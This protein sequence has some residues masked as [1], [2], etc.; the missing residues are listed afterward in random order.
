MPIEVEWPIARPRQTARRAAFLA[1]LLAGETAYRAAQVLDIPYDRAK[2]WRSEFV[3]S[4][5]YTPQ[6]PPV[7]ALMEA[8]L[9]AKLELLLQFAQ[10]T[11]DP[12]YL[13]AQPFADLARG[14][15]GVGDTVVR[16]SERLEQVG[17]LA[18]PDRPGD[19][20]EGPAE[21]GPPAGG[22]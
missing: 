13:L 14:I 2:I 17:R 8:I 22:D 21:A 12:E 9:V 1:H 10:V 15:Q 5:R 16:L 20:L 11:N 6:S 4:G 3:V 19:D 18:E 7:M